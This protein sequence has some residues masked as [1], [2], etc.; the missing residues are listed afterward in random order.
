MKWHSHAK[1]AF[2]GSNTSVLT[3]CPVRRMSIPWNV[4]VHQISSLNL[5]RD[6][7]T[8]AYVENYEVPLENIDKLGNGVHGRIFTFLWP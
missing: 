8:A 7:L 3:I 1:F 6:A 4:F 5:N 2:S